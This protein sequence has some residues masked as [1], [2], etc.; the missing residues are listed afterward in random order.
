M[1]GGGW[2]GWGIRMIFL[3][4]AQEV[5]RFATKDFTE[6][7]TAKDLHLNELN[8]TGLISENETRISH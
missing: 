6:H 4:G 8:I 5:V 7:S 1:K 2:V 3:K